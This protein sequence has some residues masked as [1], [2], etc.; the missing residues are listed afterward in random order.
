MGNVANVGG[1][2]DGPGR[3]NDVL[4]PLPAEF[5]GHQPEEEKEFV[6]FNVL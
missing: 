2:T 4:F 1:L 6:P 3:K 5:T